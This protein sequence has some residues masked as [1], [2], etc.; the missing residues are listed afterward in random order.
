MRSRW[1]FL[2]V[3]AAFV[4]SASVADQVRFEK[5]IL[6]KTFRAEGVAVGDVNH[7]GKLDILSGDVWYAAPDWKMHEVREV[8]TYDGTKGYSNCFANFA[9][10]VN[11]DGWVDSIII[12]LPNGPCLWYENP[13]NKPGHWKQRMVVNSACNETPIFVD[14]LG[15]GRPV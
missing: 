10:D 6:D 4:C 9:Q 2:L 15:N 5:V 13:K 8:G 14:L 7:D 1:V 12:G 3:T 11:G